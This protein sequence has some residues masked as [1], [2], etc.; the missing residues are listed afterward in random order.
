MSRPSPQPALGPDKLMQVIHT[1]TEIA[2]LGLD[3]GSVMALVTERAQIMT[4]AIGAVIELAEGEDM[5]YRASTGS[6]AN[7]LGLRLKRG[8]SLSGLCV[9][10]GQPLQCDDSETDERVDRAACRKVGLRSMVVAPLKHLDSVVGVIKVLSDRPQAF[11]AEAGQILQ[12]MSNLIAS[13]MFHAAR[14][15][16]DEL[17]HRAT[18]DPLTGL[19][20]RALFYDRLRHKLLTAE[21]GHE[22]VGVLNLDMDGLKPINDQHGHQAGDAAIKEL[23]VRLKNAARE[24]DTVARLGGDEFGVILARI[25]GHSGLSQQRTRLDAAIAKPF[26]Y[27]RLELQL[28]ASIGGAVFPLDGNDPN[29]LLETADRAMYETKRARK[30][31]PAAH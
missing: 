15:E 9:Q 10:Q 23:A 16:A 7:Q 13:A 25:D 24:S 3:L 19:A 18:H 6:I 17:F 12:L 31:Q 29:Q 2:R 11:T 30:A 21:R 27:G 4:G 5:V 1:Q 20:N 22:Q 28:G 14:A 26:R 8:N